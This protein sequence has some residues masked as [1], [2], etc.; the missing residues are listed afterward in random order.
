M[1]LASLGSGPPTPNPNLTGKEFQLESFLEMK[2]GTAPH[3][4]Y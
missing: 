4:L 2:F 3:D 1:V